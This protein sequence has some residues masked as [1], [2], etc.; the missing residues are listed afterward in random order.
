MKK[1]LV[2]SL[3][4]SAAYAGPITLPPEPVGFKEGAGMEL[5]MAQCLTCHSSQYVTIQ[6]VF[7][8]AFWKA[9]VEKMAAKYGAPIPPEQVAPLVDYLVRNYGNEKP[10]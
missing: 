2:F 4:A 3:L 1:Y 9:S 7:P 10:Q 6:P 8:R 5:V